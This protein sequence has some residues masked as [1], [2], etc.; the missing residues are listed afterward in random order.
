MEI[1][2]KVVGPV[3]ICDLKSNVINN[4]SYIVL[5]LEDDTNVYYVFDEKCKKNSIL[6]LKKLLV[7]LK[8]LTILDELS[9]NFKI[10]ERHLK[11]IVGKKVIYIEKYYKHSY[12]VK[13]IANTKKN[14]LSE[15]KETL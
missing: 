4:I 10:L 3:T 8:E 13:L 1:L 14:L 15:S 5:T 7:D 9:L 2:K 12:K 11:K 6:E